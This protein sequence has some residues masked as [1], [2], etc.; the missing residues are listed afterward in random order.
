MYRASIFAPLPYDKYKLSIVIDRKH[1]SNPMSIAHA[2]TMTKYQI[3][4]QC[5][6]SVAYITYRSLQT[7]GSC[8][9]LK[10]V[11]ILLL[12]YTP[13]LA[14]SPPSVYSQICSQIEHSLYNT[15]VNK[16]SG[17]GVGCLSIL[18]KC[19]DGMTSYRDRSNIF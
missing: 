12:K 18:L 7:C 11:D 13:D 3:K 10:S 6:M 4:C 5:Q 14:Q 9:S 19:E 17:S 16:P 2:Q 15:N 1:F 8:R